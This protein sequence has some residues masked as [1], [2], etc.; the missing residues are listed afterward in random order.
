M[1]VLIDRAV[2]IGSAWQC[3]TFQ[4]SSSH[5]EIMVTRSDDGVIS[6]RPAN[7]TSY[8]SSWTM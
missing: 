4:E 3:T 5:R 1:I 2:V 6:S 8:R 7:F